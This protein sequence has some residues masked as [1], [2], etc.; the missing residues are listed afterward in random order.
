MR[1]PLRLLLAC[2]LLASGLALALTLAAPSSRSPTHA[3]SQQGFDG[4]LLPKG[5]PAATFTLTDQR[6]RRISAVKYR[7]RVTILAF[8]N[9]GCGA[10]CFLTAEQIRGAL[11][12]LPPGMPTLLISTDPRTDTPGRVRRFLRRTS[13]AGRVQYLT[14]SP[15]QLAVLAREYGAGL[16]GGTPAAK[17]GGS[18]PGPSPSAKRPPSTTYVVLIDTRGEPR[19]G[20]TIEQLTPEALAHDIRRLKRA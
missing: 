12:E 13:L 2:L 7:G 9:S 16:L 10:P 14:G 18:P 1:P 8:L 4:P 17:Q 3:R 6:G 15:S 11:D 20:Y 19:I 5:S